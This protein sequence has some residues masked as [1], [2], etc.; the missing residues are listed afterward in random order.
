MEMKLHC[1]LCYL[2]HR[3]LYFEYMKTRVENFHLYLLQMEISAKLMH[4]DIIL[5]PSA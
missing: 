1:F 4:G 5:F 2:Y 3:T